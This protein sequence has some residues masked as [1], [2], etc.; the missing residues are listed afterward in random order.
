[1]GQLKDP[2]LLLRLAAWTPRVFFLVPLSSK[3]SHGKLLRRLCYGPICA[4]ADG[5][6]GAGAPGGTENVS[7]SGA[8]PT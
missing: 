7:R 1:M 2:P 5:D 3:T 4:S 6:A 8:I